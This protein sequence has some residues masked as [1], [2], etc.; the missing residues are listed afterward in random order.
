MRLALK[1][2]SFPSHKGVLWSSH[3]DK[4]ISPP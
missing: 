3:L 1:L 2:V 4:H